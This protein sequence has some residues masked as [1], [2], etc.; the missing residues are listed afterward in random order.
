MRPD[1]GMSPFVVR[2]SSLLLQAGRG[3][4]GGAISIIADRSGSGTALNAGTITVTGLLQA[5]ATGTSTF[6]EGRGATGGTID[7]NGASYIR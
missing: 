1:S 2:P 5:L 4:V 7:F 3:P 6:V